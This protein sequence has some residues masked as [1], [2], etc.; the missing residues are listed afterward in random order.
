[1]HM[2]EIQFAYKAGGKLRRGFNT[3][4]STKAGVTG[5]GIPVWLRPKCLLVRL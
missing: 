5:I 4:I 2:T 1:M 3:A